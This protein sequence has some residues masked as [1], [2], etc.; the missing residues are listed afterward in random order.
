MLAG[1]TISTSGD[2]GDCTALLARLLGWLGRWLGEWCG[3]LV[4]PPLLPLLPVRCREP[5][6]HSSDSWDG[7]IR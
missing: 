6:S 4:L 2:T 5:A 7:I 3:L 1:R